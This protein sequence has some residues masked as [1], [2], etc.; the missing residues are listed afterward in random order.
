MLR[1]STGPVVFPCKAG[2]SVPTLAYFH[3][4]CQLLLWRLLATP[5]YYETSDRRPKLLLDLS[6]ISS[7]H[8][9]LMHGVPVKHICLVTNNW[10][11]SVIYSQEN[12]HLSGQSSLQSYCDF[13]SETFLPPPRI[14][15]SSAYFVY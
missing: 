9:F 11:R 10:P 1:A 15:P 13:M 2:S 12:S 8:A 3:S 6:G 4:L 5:V 7:Y 14:L